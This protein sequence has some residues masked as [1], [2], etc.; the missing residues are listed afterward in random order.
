MFIIVILIFTI[1][2]LVEI[3]PLY[4]NKQK[5]ELILYSILLASSFILSILMSFGIKLPSVSSFIKVI[6]DHIV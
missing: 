5:K 4:K 1:I 2:A 6:V 3:K